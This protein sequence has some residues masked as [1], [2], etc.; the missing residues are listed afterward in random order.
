[1]TR[2]GSDLEARVYTDA[3]IDFENGIAAIGVVIVSCADDSIVAAYSSVLP[4]SSTAA[5][6]E[7]EA[8]FSG[9][10]KAVKLGFGRLTVHTDSVVA[11][12]A[13]ARPSGNEDKELH[14]IL[15]KLYKIR[16]QVTSLSIARSSREDVRFAHRLAFKAMNKRR[17]RIEREGDVGNNKKG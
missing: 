11:K 7:A 1:M 13:L 2:K 14:E 5:V 6:A 16:G 10:R 9:V 4:R 17:Q 3:S 12:D 15:L 8:I